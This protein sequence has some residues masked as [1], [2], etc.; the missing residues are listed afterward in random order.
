ME[1]IQLK[2]EVVMM[3]KKM[4]EEYATVQIMVIL[5]EGIMGHKMLAPSLAYIKAQIQPNRL[6]LNYKTA[7]LLCWKLE[8]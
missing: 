8:Q 5:K 3:G 2:Q 4:V 1:E 7:P 6:H